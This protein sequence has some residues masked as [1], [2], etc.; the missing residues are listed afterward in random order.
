MFYDMCIDWWY[1]KFAMEN[2]SH[3]CPGCNKEEI[4]KLESYYV[5]IS[6]TEVV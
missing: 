4:G 1:N 3:K 6:I 5:T 2:K